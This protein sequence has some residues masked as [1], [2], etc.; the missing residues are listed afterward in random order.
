M[1]NSRGRYIIPFTITN[2]TTAPFLQLA[3]PTNAGLRILEFFVGQE[4]G[5]TAEQIAIQAA[6]RTTASTLPTAAAVNK[7]DP[8]DANSR[9]ATTT[10]TNAYGIASATGTLG[11]LLEVFT[12]DCR[13]G[14]QYAPSDESA[15]SIMDVSQFLTFH[16]KAAPSAN[17]YSGFVKVEEI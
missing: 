15:A 10:T 3:T 1:P 8:T 4:A 5:E 13:V 12:G 16:F 2:P 11:D 9:L 7:L 17:V 6:R 14:V